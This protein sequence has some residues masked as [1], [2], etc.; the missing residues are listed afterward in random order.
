MTQTDRLMTRLLSLPTTSFH[1]DSVRAVVIQ[2]LRRMR[3][4]FRIDRHG[5]V[6]AHLRRGRIHPPLAMVAHMDHPGFMLESAPLARARACV[7][8]VLGGVGG[9]LVGKR[10]RFY[11]AGRVIGTISSIEDKGAGG[12]A[13]RV[14]AKLRTPLSGEMFALW[15]VPVFRRRNNKIFART[16]DD[17]CGV[18]VMLE[19]LK[20]L[21]RR[22]GPVDVYACFTRAEEVG[23]VGAAGLAKSRILPKKSRV[24][25]IEM[26][27]KIPGRAEQ[28]RGFVVRVGDRAGIFDP[29]LSRFLIESARRLKS[30]R[31]SF[32]YQI[33]VLDGGVCEA[34]LFNAMGYSASGVALPLGNYHNRT[35][36]GGIGAEFIDGRDLQGLTEFLTEI[37]QKMDWNENAQAPT[38]QRFIKQFDRWKKHL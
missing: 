36:S 6:I 29:R 21:R 22:A 23:F 11:P 14:R 18:A 1:E 15:D 32:Q 25:S 4:S 3:V 33:A 28:G 38:R 2:R 7:L 27:R 35:P 16:I 5:N 34:S 37:A 26:S 9:N 30:K 8:R 31:A 13:V 24:V 19:V 17:V 20:R 10:I 12:R